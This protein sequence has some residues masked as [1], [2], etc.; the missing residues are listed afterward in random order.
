MAPNSVTVRRLALAAPVLLLLYGILRFADGLD[1]HRGAGPLRDAGHLAFF[2]GMALFGLLAVTLRGMLPAP[3]RVATA[4]A[5]AAVAGVL[6][7]LWVITGD[8]STAFRKAAPPPGALRAAGPMLFPLGV[9]VL[10]GL[11][12]AARRLP[13]RT[14]LL[15]GAGIAAITVDLDLLPFA[16]VT[17]LVA[18]APLRRVT[19]P[20]LLRPRLAT[21]AH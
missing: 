5:V 11:L 19:R 6:C 14:P 8:L 15:F 20:G 7:F 1:G 16:A 21:L 13:V 12:V 18:L 17:I 9:L 4:A 2:A 10:F 3:G